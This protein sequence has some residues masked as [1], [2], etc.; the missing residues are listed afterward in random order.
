MCKLNVDGGAETRLLGPSTFHSVSQER[1]RHPN[2]STEI[3]WAIGNSGNG[4]RKR[5]MENRNNQ[6]LINYGKTF[7]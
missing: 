2:D 5:R 6:I 1:N 7:D 3:L 4:N